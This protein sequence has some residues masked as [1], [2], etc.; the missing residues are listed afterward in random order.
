MLHPIILYD[1]VCGLC[2]RLNQF[3]L[4]RDRED[5]FRFASL[6][7]PLAARILARHGVNPQDL[8]SVYVVLNHD[9]TK[10]AQADERLLPRSDAAIFVLKR[11][12]G[13]WKVLGLFVQFLPRFLRDWGYR[14][15]A[16]NRYRVFGRFETCMLPSARDRSKFI[17]S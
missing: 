5:I 3:V 17:D 6:Q 14:V 12:G 11:L 15:V 2:N 9:L 10:E 7:S 1:G 16:R 8:D 13:I 4:R